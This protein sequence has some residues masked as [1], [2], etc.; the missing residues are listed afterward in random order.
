MTRCIS[1]KTTVQSKMGNFNKL[2]P[3][4][5]REEEE[6]KPKDK[7]ASTSSRK[8]PST[9]VVM[10]K[11]ELLNSQAVSPIFNISPICCQRIQRYFL[12]YLA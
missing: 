1:T 5:R 8:R 4:V 9:L 3:I 2:M 10:L 6:G 11:E 7:V 12:F